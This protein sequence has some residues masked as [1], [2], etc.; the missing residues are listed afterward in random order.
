M[1]LSFDPR[2]HRCFKNVSSRAYLEVGP[3][4]PPALGTIK[5]NAKHGNANV[6]A[7]S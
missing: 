3:G 4:R 6:A 1:S 7:A 5:G 2:I